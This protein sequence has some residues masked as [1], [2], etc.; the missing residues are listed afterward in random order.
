MVDF[1]AYLNILWLISLLFWQLMFL[2]F[3]NNLFEN[4]CSWTLSFSTYKF[5]GTMIFWQHKPIQTFLS[6]TWRA[7]WIV[8]TLVSM[9]TIIPNPF[10]TPLF[11]LIQSDAII[12][13]IFDRLSD[14]IGVIMIEVFLELFPTL[15]EI[16]SQ[17]ATKGL[18]DQRSWMEF[19]SV[20]F[21]VGLK[22]IWVAEYRLSSF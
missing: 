12:L 6:I 10:F 7:A 17:N 2:Y 1:P 13:P 20:I 9:Q 3:L 15:N 8:P 5:Y 16:A 4:H 21:L 22:D 11:K 18:L 19:I 14:N